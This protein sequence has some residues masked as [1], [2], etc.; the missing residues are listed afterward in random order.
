MCCNDVMKMALVY[1]ASGWESDNK[2]L[3]WMDGLEIPSIMSMDGTL[4]CKYP[5]NGL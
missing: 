4:E 3:V 2:G 1:M 5:R